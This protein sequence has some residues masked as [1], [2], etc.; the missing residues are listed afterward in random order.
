MVFLATVAVAALSLCGIV[1]M[2]VIGKH[3]N[4]LV[5]ALVALSAGA[6]LG[7]AAFHLLPESV[8]L[9]QEN[10]LEL[11][12]PMLILVG[13]F[14]TSFFFERFFALH[15]C[16]STAH[17]GDAAS[18]LRCQH[19]VKPYTQLVLLN[20]AVHNVIDGLVIAASFAVSPALGVTT[21]VS[22]ALH[23]VP[24]ELG[25]Y[26]VL[27]HGGYRR[28][29]ALW[30][31]ALAASTVIVGGLVGVFVAS[32]V[33]LAV[34]VLL[35]FAAGGFLY[36]ASADLLPELRHEEKTGQA[37]WHALIFVVGI[38]IMAATSFLE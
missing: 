8:E 17:H 11:F 24:Q 15:H 32:S 29:R 38:A 4:A 10:G 27:V 19:E 2:F 12:V 20:D 6:M 34:P 28:R 23:E 9:A 7:N 26:A 30:L 1:T 13:A 3:F 16:H 37:I 14:V 33:E 22:I 25:D 36:I 35:P 31:N 5:L 18:T 21:A